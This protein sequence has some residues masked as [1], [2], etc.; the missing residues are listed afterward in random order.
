MQ[1]G[2]SSAHDQSNADAS[3]MLAQLPS[4]NDAGSSEWSS[5]TLE[6]RSVSESDSLEHVVGDDHHL[7]QVVK[8]HISS[9]TENLV[10]SK[11]LKRRAHVC[12]YLKII[13]CCGLRCLTIRLF[14]V[15]RN[16]CSEFHWVNSAIFCMKILCESWLY[17]TIII[18]LWLTGTV[19]WILGGQQRHI[20]WVIWACESP[21]AILT[22]LLLTFVLTMS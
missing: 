17:Y 3:S 9:T 18:S 12:I 13:Q 11:I 1:S 20:S 7:H 21:E 22:K 16:H 8:S 14:I 6:P 10:I 19:A 15:S 2:P 4:S 5:V